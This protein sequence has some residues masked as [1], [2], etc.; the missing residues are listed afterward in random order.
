MRFFNWQT[1][2]RN[3][4]AAA[5]GLLVTAVLVIAGAAVV[6][7]KYVATSQMVLLPPSNLPETSYNGVQNPYL[8]LSGLQSMAAVVSSAMMDDDTAKALQAAGV[9]DYNV[10]WDA[11]SAGPV[12]V[13]QATEPS[14]AQ[15]SN[16]ISVLDEQIPMTV[17]RLQNA[18]SISPRSFITTSVIARPS[19][20]ARSGKT[21]LRVA[22]LALVI[23]LVLT[24]LA[25]SVL[26]GWRVRRQA[27]TVGEARKR[28]EVVPS[29]PAVAGTAGPE[30]PEG[31][32]PEQVVLADAA[33]DT[34]SSS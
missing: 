8:G 27:A 33:R 17:A 30:N 6:P 16:A 11:L 4:V 24:M 31:A 20:P 22:L 7:A 21:Q 5:C 26:D 28:A 12:L 1:F 25:I 3:W 32:K 18:A 29:F 13:V 14:A 9:S 23:G 10:Q 2:R 34:R 19:T 15:A